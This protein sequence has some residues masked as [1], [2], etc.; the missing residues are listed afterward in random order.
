M[1]EVSTQNDIKKII[2]IE[3]ILKVLFFWIYI[4]VGIML[5]LDTDEEE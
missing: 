5:L 3:N 4:P 2:T 1:Y